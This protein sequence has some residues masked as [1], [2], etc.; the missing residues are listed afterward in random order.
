MIEQLRQPEQQQVNPYY[1]QPE[2]FGFQQQNSAVKIPDIKN[3]Y[4][5]NSPNIY[6]QNQNRSSP[7]NPS[8]N[9][10]INVSPDVK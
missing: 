9:V 6:N 10:K 2:Y 7:N 5:D 1:N 8:S 4:D 3:I